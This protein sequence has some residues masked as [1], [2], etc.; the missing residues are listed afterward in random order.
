LMTSEDTCIPHVSRMYLASEIRTSPDTFEIHVS[1][2]V[3]LMYPAC[4]H[5]VSSNHCRYMYPICIP[6]VSHMYL[7]C[8]LRAFL[9]AGV[10]TLKMLQ[11]SAKEMKRARTAA[12]QLEQLIDLKNLALR[13]FQP[14]PEPLTLMPPSGAQLGV[15]WGLL[16]SLGGFVI[17]IRI[18]CIVHVSCMYLAC[19]LMC[20]VHILVH[21]DTSR[22]IEI[23]LY[24]HFGHHRK[25]IFI[26]RDMYPSLRYM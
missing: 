8:N 14:M 2:Y 3:S 6:H 7:L 11:G 25:C 21:Q 1:H 17:R 9:L 23:H 15:T 12:V 5:H 4:I 24:L 10:S 16:S 18:P 13:Y 19:I 22:Y 26:P 20:P